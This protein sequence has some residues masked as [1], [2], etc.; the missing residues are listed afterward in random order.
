LVLSQSY[1]REDKRTSVEALQL[2][3]PTLTRPPVP[4]PAALASSWPL[5]T[6][7]VLGL[8]LI[9]GGVIWYVRSQQA[10]TF[11]PYE[12]PGYRHTQGRRIVRTSRASRIRPRP[13]ALPPDD[14]QDAAG[15]CTQCGK[16]LQP[17]DIFCSRCGTRVKGK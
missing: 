9:A 12:P 16:P 6:A 17:D 8:A 4:G 3:T 2:V 15:F 1:H 11:R 14:T 13:I 7:L 10:G 5:I